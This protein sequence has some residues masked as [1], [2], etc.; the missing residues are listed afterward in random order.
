MNATTKTILAAAGLG[1]ATVIA[2]RALVRRSRRIDMAGRTAIVT[3]GSRGLG[4]VLA[5]ELVDE[6]VRVALLARTE[7]DLQSAKADLESRGGVAEYFVCDVSNRQRVNDAVRQAETKLGPIDLLFNVAGIIEVGPLDAMTEE[8]FRKSMDINCWGILHTT[9]AVL[10]GMRE[11]RFGRIVN[12]ASIGG[13]RAVPHMLPYAA[14]KFAAVGLSNGLRAELAKDGILVST[15]CP[16]LMR[17][18]SPR[19]ATFKGQ[20]R[21]EYAWFSIGDSLPIASM[22]ARTAA[23]QTIDACRYGDG[24]VLLRTPLN[25]GVPLQSLFPGLTRD[26]L[27]LANRLLPEMGGIG[28]DSAYGYESFSEWSPSVLTTLTEK[29]A[30]RNNE[31]RPR[32]ADAT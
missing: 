17:T 21:K 14:S 30:E 29:A 31:M 16:S 5:R 9:L 13:K 4:L 15:V 20:H 7:A 22:D 3:G 11:R 8:D 26:A 10:P 19:N 12:I 18:G 32:P 2:A 25:I 28:K 1:A 23:R 6:G 27:A 24:E